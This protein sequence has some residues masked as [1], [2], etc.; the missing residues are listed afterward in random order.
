MRLLIASC[1]CLWAAAGHGQ[2]VE[3]LTGKVVAE[4]EQDRTL[5]SKAGWL[6][7]LHVLGTDLDEVPKPIIRA[8]VP[9]ADEDQVICARITTRTGDYSAMVQYEVSGSSS[10]DG[11]QAL[12]NYEASSPLAMAHTP[13]TGGVALERGPCE[14]D[15]LANLG[16][17]S[18]FFVN[19][20]NQAGEP[21]LDENGNAT[22]VMHINVSRADTLRAT[23]SLG[24]GSVSVPCQP[25][26][27]PGALAYNF[28]CRLLLAP[29]V[30]DGSYGPFIEFEYRRIYRGNESRSRRA[31][32]YLGVG[33][34]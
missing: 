32:L 31:H 20:W 29:G 28:E 8:F 26:V 3:E 17:V 18:E 33:D 4:S 7:G 30:L 34:P 10:R 11:I 22:L 14:G 1:L 5:I 23:A 6:R 27:D 13:A 24:G 2:E 19:F 9:P 15:A 21:E 25:L 16:K 12:L